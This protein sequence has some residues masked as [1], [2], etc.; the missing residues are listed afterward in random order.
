V[1]DQGHLIVLGADYGYAAPPGR[2][3]VMLWSRTPWEAVDALGDVALPTGRYVAGRTQT[4]AGPLNVVGVCI[5]WARA[6][7]S[8][9]RRNRRPWEDHLADLAALEQ[10][11]KRQAGATLMLGDQPDDPAEPRAHPGV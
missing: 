2:R 7:V 4:P 1:D 10:P 9:G 5:P 3:K 6:H 8:T 11:L